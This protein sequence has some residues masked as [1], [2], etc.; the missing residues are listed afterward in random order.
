MTANQDISQ[1]SRKYDSDDRQILVELLHEYSQKLISVS[2]TLIECK[3]SS[4]RKE[5]LERIISFPPFI[6]LF[7]ISFSYLFWTFSYEVSNHDLCKIAGCNFYE[8]VDFHIKALFSAVIFFPIVL[9]LVLKTPLFNS[10]FQANNKSE[11]IQADLLERE[12]RMTASQ[13]ESAMRLTVEIADQVETNLARKLE[14]DLRVSDASHSL[15]Y[16]YSV[17]GS[18]PKKTPKSNKSLLRSFFKFVQDN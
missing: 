11:K 16:Y 4:D 2:R 7:S 13:L 18:R 17:V 5:W 9:F 1:K 6:L 10:F 8:R 15:E 12:A 14:L 3:G